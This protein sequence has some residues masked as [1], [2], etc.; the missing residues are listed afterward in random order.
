M[1][2]DPT[3]AALGLPLGGEPGDSYS[4]TIEQLQKQVKQYI[5]KKL[6]GLMN[7]KCRQTSTIAWDADEYFSN[8]RVR[9]GKQQS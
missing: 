9:T 7:E 4:T 2:T 5:M 3:L 6:D 1:N 8:E